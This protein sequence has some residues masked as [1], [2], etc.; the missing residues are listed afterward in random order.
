[1]LKFFRIGLW[2]LA[3]MIVL[4]AGL[5]TYLR[6]ADLSVYE[7]Q[8]EAFLSD[9]IGHRLEID[10]RFELQVRNLTGLTAEDVTLSNSDWPSE[11][12]IVKVGHVSITIDL[13]S[14][15]RGPLIIEELDVRDIRAYLER[16]AEGQANWMTGRP[17]SA[18]ANELDT[19]LIAFRDVNIE[20]VQILYVDPARRLPLDIS[21]EQLVVSPDEN[22]ILDLDLQGAVNELP[23]WAD[24]KLGPWQNLLEGKDLTADLDMTLSQVRLAVTGSAEDMRTLAG[25]EATIDWSGPSIGRVTDRL[26]L[27]PFAE[28]P[29]KVEGRLRKLGSGNQVRLEGIFGEINV[30]VSGSVDSLR[31]PSDTALDFSVTGPNTQRVAELLGIDGAPAV[32]YQITGDFSQHGRRL[33]FNGTRAQLGENSVAFD[34]WVDSGRAPRD[35]DVT[36]DA[37]GPDFSVFGPFIGVDGV[38]AEAFDIEGRIGKTGSDWRF[39]DVTAT[40]GA[41]R[42]VATGSISGD[43][44]T[45][46]V[47]S[48]VGPDN[49]FLHAMTGLEGLPARPYN[50]SARIRPDRSGVQLKDASALFGE[51]RIDVD[52]IVATRKGFVGTRLDVRASGP[53]LRNV[54]LL[55]G[56][57]YVPGGSYEVTG[58][59]EIDRAGLVVTDLT[60]SVH[61]MK[62]SANGRVGLGDNL[63][64]FDVTVS[65]HGPNFAGLANF[66]WMQ[67]L[68]GESF[69]ITGRGKRRGKHYELNSVDVSIG[70][71]QAY[72]EG[73]VEKDGFSADVLVRG[74]AD[75][76]DV[77]GKLLGSSEMPDGALAANAQLRFGQGE[78][79]LT[80]SELK[81]G[82][83]ML[84]ANGT[85]SFK[86]LS[87]DSDLRFSASGPNL[88]QIGRAFGLDVF[89]AKPFTVAGEFSGTPSGFAMRDF[90]ATIGSNDVNGTFTADLRDKPDIT[91]TLSSNFLDLTERLQQATEQLENDDAEPDELLFPD[92]PL[93]PEWLDFADAD[94]DVNVG[95]LKVNQTSVNDFHVRL[96]LSDGSLTI[97]PLSF[98][99]AEGRMDGSLELRPQNG[100]YELIASASL[101][102][103]RLGLLGSGE[104]DMLRRPPLNGTFELRGAGNS[105]HQIMVSSSGRLSMRHGSG[106]IPNQSSRLFGDLILEVLRIFNPLKTESEFR[107]FDCG[108]YDVMIDDGVATIEDFDIQTDALTTLA[109]GSVSFDTE[110]VDISIRAKPREGIGISIG[111]LANSFVKVGG[112]LRAPKLVLDA[113]GTAATTGAAVATGGLSILAK[114]LMDRLSAAADI[115]AQDEANEED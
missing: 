68:S 5:F 66:D 22:D 7:D 23:L 21:I 73:S 54:A 10:G 6:S 113:K 41:N 49:S 106:Q 40:V 39:D 80:D 60:A 29:F 58:G 35:L 82:D 69:S 102:N 85:L 72:L 94:F 27:P 108:I 45:E 55:T 95:K 62:G 36:I 46:I 65:A 47:F 100:D 83:Y 101:E 25:V 90:I 1:M 109:S 61:D 9:K 57:L 28:G 76:P 74:V 26:G 15:I 84:I 56:L 87:N 110:R 70:T 37:A 32:P 78:L 114:G 11:Q 67:R 8:I 16:D 79:E 77:L 24:G 2:V 14:L 31:N 88:D 38:P 103:L 52:G 63:G 34:G 20:S 12:A 17:V 98:R 50:V 48:A 104:Q 115:C 33:A 112:T 13:W 93:K 53:E 86:P 97:A 92:E 18:K 99:D 111:G 44:D 89:P 4:T 75:S 107:N 105:I 96:Q 43:D 3:V 91:G 81:V 19:E 71:L 51:H 42:L 30:L 64:D 59:L